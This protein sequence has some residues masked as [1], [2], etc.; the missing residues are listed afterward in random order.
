[1]SIK[2]NPLPPTPPPTPLLPRPLA[3]RDPPSILQSRAD[4]FMGGVLLGYLQLPIKGPPTPWEPPPHLH[5]P[6]NTE[7]AGAGGGL[8]EPGP[9]APTHLL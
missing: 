9:P 6:W 4:T 2:H 5:R 7:D 8:R 3:H 1:M